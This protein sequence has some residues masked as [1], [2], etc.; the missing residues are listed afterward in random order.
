MLCTQVRALEDELTTRQTE[1][2]GLKTTVAEMSSSRA[3][4]EAGLSAAR[5]E[6]EGART[7]IGQLQTDNRSQA[8]RCYIVT[9]VIVGPGQG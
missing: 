4:L 8:D 1:V 5:M 7:R 3:G 6:L 2:A 9:I